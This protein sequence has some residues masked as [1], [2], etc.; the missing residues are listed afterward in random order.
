MEDVLGDGWTSGLH[1]N[2]RARSLR[3]HASAIA[4]RRPF[5][6]EFRFRRHDGVYRWMISAGRPVEDSGGGFAGFIGSWVD[7][8]E[9]KQA[10]EALKAGES[11]LRM[12]QRVGHIGS[13]EWDLRSGSMTWSANR[14]S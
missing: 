4:A 8:S 14:R 2:D 3:L 13:W 6:M 5:E 1:P 7:I 9:R 12:S 10:E 11:F